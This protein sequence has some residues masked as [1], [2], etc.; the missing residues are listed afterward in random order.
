MTGF[1]IGLIVGVFWG[2]AIGFVVAALCAAAKRKPQI[3]PQQS[4]KG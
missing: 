2:F 1:W 3:A 4:K